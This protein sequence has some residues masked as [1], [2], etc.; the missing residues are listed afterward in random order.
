MQQS[1]PHPKPPIDI[2]A[3]GPNS[4]PKAVYIGDSSANAVLRSNGGSSVGFNGTTFTDGALGID[5]IVGSPQERNVEESINE[6]I[7]LTLAEA[8]MK[9]PVEGR[10]RRI[11]NFI[12]TIA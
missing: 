7:G 11:R 5:T 6:N 9:A 1:F 2:S 12:F 10:G 8:K 4:A 3:L